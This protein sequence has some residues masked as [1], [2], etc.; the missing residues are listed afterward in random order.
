MLY[1]K[2]NIIYR[3]KNGDLCYMCGIA[4]IYRL[5]RKG[6]DLPI[7]TA[8][9]QKLKQRGPDGSGTYQDGGV[10]FG[11]QRLKI[12]DLSDAAKQPMVSRCGRYVINFNGEIY[13]YK[14]IQQ[15]L[16]LHSQD[17]RSTC[18][19][20]ILLEAWAAWGPNLL[21]QTTGQFAFAI[22]DRNENRLWLARDRFGEKPLFYFTDATS[23]TFA[24]NLGALVTAPHV[25]REL[26]PEAMLEFATL[27][28]VVAPRT[29]L[30]GVNKLPPGTLLRFDHAGLEVRN[31]YDFQYHSK[32]KRATKIP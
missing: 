19:T 13:N 25:P 1:L 12:L 16:G 24:S 28:Y 22:Y 6:D 11:H 21:E 18:D 5:T 30:R 2:T 7:V 4:G 32:K 27:R 23:L 20:E 10:T 14:D 31:W 17:L 8:M 15:K 29:V 3:R 9:M 26:D